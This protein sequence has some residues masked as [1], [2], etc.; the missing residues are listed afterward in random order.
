[1]HLSSEER[2][3]VNTF[4]FHGCFEN[5][6]GL[7]AG[8]NPYCPFG[9]ESIDPVNEHTWPDLP[10][11][12]FQ[13]SDSISSTEIGIGEAVG[14]CVLFFSCCE[15]PGGVELEVTEVGEIETGGFVVIGRSRNFMWKRFLEILKNWSNGIFLPCTKSI[16][17]TITWLRF[18][19]A[20]IW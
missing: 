9:P 17:K 8:G 18:T 7:F 20:I 11:T 19:E 12:T 2:L 15:F 1:M 6:P 4:K 10:A 3:F 13:Y 5:W 14:D 16:E